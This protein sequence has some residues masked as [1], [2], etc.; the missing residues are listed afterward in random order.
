MRELNII[1]PHSIY[2]RLGLT[3]KSQQP[4]VINDVGTTVT[5]SRPIGGS[6]FQCQIEKAI[7]R[8]LAYAKRGR[9]RFKQGS[10]Q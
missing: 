6:A 1:T 8:K 2:Q 10:K 3:N 5:F 7:G 4:S 9:A